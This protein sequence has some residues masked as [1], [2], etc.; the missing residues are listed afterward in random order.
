[1]SEIIIKIAEPSDAGE[2][3]KI[4]EPYV[5][6]TAVTFEYDVPAADEFR[7]RIEHT[8]KKYPYLKAVR[9]GEIV[10][11][12]YAGAFKGRAAYDWAVE[13]SIYLK[14]G[15]K[16]SGI[17]R[18]LYTALENIL[19]VQNILNVNACIA[20]PSEKDGHL[21]KDSVYFHEKMNCKFVGEFHMCG[22]KFG[23]WYDMVWMEKHIGIHSAVPSKVRPFCEIREEAFGILQKGRC[24]NN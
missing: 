10:G 1:M 5:L 13:T 23:T 9:G 3:V 24:K 22:F 2:L 18:K 11:Y 17:G 7:E 8:L 20:Y 6:N 21:T 19:R 14:D 12:A 4:Y 16:R 15:K